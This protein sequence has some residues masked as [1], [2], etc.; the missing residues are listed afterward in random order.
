MSTIKNTIVSLVM[1]LIT[2]IVSVIGMLA[3]FA[4]WNNGL[5]NKFEEKTRKLFNK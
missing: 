5:G 3:G 1:T 2:G 4:I